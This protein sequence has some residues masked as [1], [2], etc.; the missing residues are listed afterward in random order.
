MV[1]FLYLSHSTYIL[2]KAS[3]HSFN[4]RYAL[5]ISSPLVGIS[6]LFLLRLLSTVVSDSPKDNGLLEDK[7]NL[8]WVYL[9]FVLLVNI[10]IFSST[11]VR[12]VAK[13]RHL[14]DRDQLTGLYNRL[15][16]DREISILHQ[17][18]LRH[19]HPYA[20]LLMD[21]DHFKKINDTYGHLAGDKVLQHAA[22]LFKE[23]IRQGDVLG[24]FGGEEFMVLLPMTTLRQAETVANKLLSVLR[25]HPVDWKG[26][27]IS[28]TTSIGIASVSDASCSSDYESIL[29]QADKALYH[30]KEA[31]RDRAMAFAR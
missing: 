12:L 31:G 19:Q 14:A 28:L 6:L 8:Y 25:S 23:H 20:L 26:Q 4:N 10:T 24:R 21:L 1:A 11:L 15:L 17:Q 18:Y 3:V 27:S 16:L 30:A 9:L 5:A 22:A 2:Y 29:Q 13:I 7:G